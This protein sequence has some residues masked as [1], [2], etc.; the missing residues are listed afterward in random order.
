MKSLLAGL[1]VVLAGSPVPGWAQVEAHTATPEEVRA[2]EAGPDKVK[3]E[4][5][6]TS[7]ML[8]E[9]P[10]RSV[11]GIPAP[12]WMTKMKMPIWSSRDTGRFVCDRARVQVV[13]FKHG[14]P[15]KDFVPITLSAR[16]T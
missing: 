12:A 9:L 2:V 3:A 5:Q 6:M 15:K 10:L 1:V 11:S 16:I 4:T 8:L 14:K 13:M 7:P